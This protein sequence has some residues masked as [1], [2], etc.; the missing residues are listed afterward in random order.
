MGK[1][2]F[3]EALERA[4][5]LRDNGKAKEAILIYVDIATLAEEEKNHPLAARA[6]HAAGVAALTTISRN[7]Q[8]KFH[9][10]S[11]FLS[12]AYAAFGSA[13]DRLNQG[14]V[15]RDIGIA[16]DRVGN[17][18]IALESFQRSLEFLSEAEDVAQLAITSDK[19]GL[20]FTRQK[21]PQVGRPHIEKALELLRQTPTSGFF[22]ATS[23]FDRSVTQFADHQFDGAL[24]DAEEALGWFEADH[25][26]MDYNLRRAQVLALLGLIYQQLGQ[27]KPAR[28]SIDQSSRLLKS[29]DDDVAAAV[30]EDI[31][32]WTDLL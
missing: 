4:D 27:E 11:E 6:F 2:N 20:H 25:G 9:Q 17:T 8:S 28:Q 31:K 14:A 21:Q 5:I 13:N 26:A 7:Q 3:E 32:L 15:L 10:A 23:L 30:T 16:A 19:L 18:A 29:F 12:R 1:L 22:R 24:A